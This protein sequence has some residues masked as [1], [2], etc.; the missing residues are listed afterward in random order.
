MA[1]GVLEKRKSGQ[2]VFINRRPLCLIV[3][4]DE[5]SI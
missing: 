4:K 1:W 3:M 2:S 5:P